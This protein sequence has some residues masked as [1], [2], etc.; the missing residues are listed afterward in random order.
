[1][2]DFLIHRRVFGFSDGLIQF[3]QF[4]I[5]GNGIGTSVGVN[6]IKAV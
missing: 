6:A 2:L 1:M 5:D 3:S 4:D